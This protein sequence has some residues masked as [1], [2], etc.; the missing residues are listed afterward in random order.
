MKKSYYIFVLLLISVV[1]CNTTE[2]KLT[3]APLDQTNYRDTVRG[4]NDSIHNVR[5]KL[6]TVKGFKNSEKNYATVDSFA[7]AIAK[8]EPQLKNL[9]TYQIIIYKVSSKTNSGWLKNNPRDLVRYS[10]DHDLILS[11]TWNSG[12]FA[13][14]IKWRD[15]EMIEPQNN[16]TVTDVY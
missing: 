7:K 5:L 16:V 11:Y 14:K 2:S 15:G 10:Q 12:K 13:T 8:S 3:F 6:Y 9:Y 4:Q 1:A